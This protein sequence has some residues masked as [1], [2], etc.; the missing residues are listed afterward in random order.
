MKK[1]RKAQ[2]TIN[3]PVEKG[4]TDEIIKEKFINDTLVYMCM[5][6]EVG[7]EGHTPHIHI[8]AQF[9]NPRSFDALVNLFDGKSHIEIAYGSAQEN[10]DYI[11]KEGKHANSDK[12]ETNLIDT[13]FEYGDIKQAEE[14]KKKDSEVV[15]ELLKDGFTPE[16]IIDEIPRLSFKLKQ[17]KE[18][19]ETIRWNKAKTED[20]DIRVTYI[21]G[22]TGTGKSR[23]IHEKYKPN[24]IYF[25]TDY[26]HPF[27]AYDGQKVLVLE[28]FRC[29]FECKEML[30]LLDRY[31]YQLKA[32]YSNKWACFTEVYVISNIKFEEQYKELARNE[33]ETYNAFIRRFHTFITMDTTSKRVYLDYDL[34]KKDISIT[35][36]EYEE[37]QHVSSSI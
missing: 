24:D 30:Q 29:D 19:Y 21:Y 5:C 14:E 22:T 3:N 15:V 1:L 25:V 37:Q 33:L 2:F 10:R 27:D 9:K 23:Y 20:R 18:I 17:I 31:P 36:E 4:F 6:H 35:L 7:L 16:D 26:K 34:Y 8:F 28:E 12:K 11:R 13:F 32:R